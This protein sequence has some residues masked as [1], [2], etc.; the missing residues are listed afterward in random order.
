MGPGARAGQRGSGKPASDW[1]MRIIL[2]SDW[3]MRVILASDW[4]I[5]LILSS[6][7]SIRLILYS[8]WLGGLG[9]AKYHNSESR[10]QQPH[11][12]MQGEMMMIRMIMLIG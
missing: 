11:S 1:S 7:W 2:S 4:S 3:S 5:R 8:H 10:L 9:G 6:D 12:R